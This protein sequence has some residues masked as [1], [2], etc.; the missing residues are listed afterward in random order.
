MGGGQPRTILSERRSIGFFTPWLVGGYHTHVARSLTVLG[1]RSLP[2]EPLYSPAR[3][4]SWAR[5][6]SL[7]HIL[8]VGSNRIQKAYKRTPPPRFPHFALT[9]ELEDAQ[10]QQ[11]EPEWFSSRCPPSRRSGCGALGGWFGF[12]ESPAGFLARPSPK[13]Q[14]VL[15]GS[16]NARQENP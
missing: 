10:A 4:D 9:H 5:R 13:L 8:K 6:D 12:P 1:S 15:R 7:P 3:R 2:D 11:L 16:R 14:V